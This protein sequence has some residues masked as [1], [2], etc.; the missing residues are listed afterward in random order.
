MNDTQKAPLEF[1]I[2]QFIDQIEMERKIEEKKSTVVIENFK[3]C[4]TSGETSNKIWAICTAR[5]DDNMVIRGVKIINGSNGAFVSMPRY[6]TK[7]TDGKE[8]YKDVVYLKTNEAREALSKAVQEAYR[9][10]VMRLDKKLSAQNRLEV[11]VSV[12]DGREDHL[13]GLAQITVG[14][15]VVKNIRIMEGKNSLFVSMPQYMNEQGKW[16]DLVYPDD[17]EIRTTIANKVL[18]EYN[19]QIKENKISEVKEIRK[20]KSKTR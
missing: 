14:N 9:E 3:L 11:K 6:K 2:K 1:D 4:N 10:C 8:I 18:E 12:Y 15:T 20:E 5:I 19:V 13:R 17:K 16:N 7:D